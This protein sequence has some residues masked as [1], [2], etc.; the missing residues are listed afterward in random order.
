MQNI[1]TINRPPEILVEGF[2][3][4]RKDYPDISKQFLDE[5]SFKQ[6]VRRFTADDLYI[7]D[8]EKLKGNLLNAIE[9]VG[10]IQLSG[11]LIPFFVTKEKAKQLRMLIGRRS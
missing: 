11:S 6:S 1:Q 4:T 10:V 5:Q 2:F 9:V 7:T 8:I 3:A